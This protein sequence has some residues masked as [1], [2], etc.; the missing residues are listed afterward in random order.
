MK[1]NIPLQLRCLLRNRC[2]LKTGASATRSRAAD[3]RPI[4]ILSVDRI[5]RQ[6]R[7]GDT[8]RL[9]D[10]ARV[11]REHDHVE[12]IPHKTMRVASRGV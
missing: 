1:H 5:L 10:R 8:I 3:L 9:N 11:R 7:Y 12:R 4:A 2:Q 6:R